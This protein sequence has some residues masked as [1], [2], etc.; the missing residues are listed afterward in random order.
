MTAMKLDM[1]GL[2]VGVVEHARKQDIRRPHP[3]IGDNQKIKD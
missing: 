1:L 2:Q 3:N